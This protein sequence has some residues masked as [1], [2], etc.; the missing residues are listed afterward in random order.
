MRRLRSNSAFAL[1]APIGIATLKL[2]SPHKVFRLNRRI[3]MN[4]DLSMIFGRRSIR[5]YA[6]GDVSDEAIK[7]ILE[8]AMSAPSAVA[9]DPWRFIVVRD[10]SI[11][12]RIVQNLPHGKMLAQAPVGIIICG[13]INVAHD[14]QL[15][16]LLQ[17]CSA[18]VENMLLAIHAL[19]LGG[20][21]LGVHPREDRVRHIQGV[22]GLPADVIPVA[23]ISIGKPGETKEPRT[24]YNPEYVHYERW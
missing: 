24:R 14:H 9:Q 22:L 19:G 3:L 8:A 12:D 21:W 13:D 16:Y 18:A 15:S 2:L 11:R 1:L 4:T 20:C 10:Q 23:A 6:P 5:T 17:D 7:S